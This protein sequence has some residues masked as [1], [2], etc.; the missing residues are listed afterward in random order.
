MN[1]EKAIELLYTHIKTIGHTISNKELQE[2]IELL[3]Y[4]GKFEEMWKE[5]GKKY[6]NYWNVCD[7]IEA[8]YLCTIMSNLE[9][10]YFPKPKDCKHATLGYAVAMHD[11]EEQTEERER[12]LIQEIEYWKFR[13]YSGRE[14]KI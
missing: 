11:Y 10:K 7:D 6:G 4:N 12:E 14:H 13:N 2:I 3:Y 9:Q 1:T 5:L 8:G